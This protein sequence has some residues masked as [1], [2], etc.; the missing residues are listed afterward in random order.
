VD[1]LGPSDVRCGLEPSVRHRPDCDS[2]SDS[3][4]DSDADSDADASACDIDR[5]L[6]RL[7]ANDSSD[8]N[9]NDY[10]RGKPCADYPCWTSHLQL[11]WHIHPALT[12]FLL[13]VRLCR[14]AKAWR[15]ASA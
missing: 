14:N 7:D 5:Y 15:F 10:S 3:D 1:W 11:R 13:T 6:V 8:P 4:C 12:P 2:D 9:E